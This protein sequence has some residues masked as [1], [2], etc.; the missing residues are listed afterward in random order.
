MLN[1]FVVRDMVEDAYAGIILGRPFLSTS[2]YKIDVKGGHLRFDMGE[3]HTEFSLF[4]DRNFLPSLFAC[5]EVIISNAIVKFDNLCPNDPPMFDCVSTKGL[6]LDCANVG[7]DAH[8]ALIITKDEPYVFNEE[9]MNDCY[10]FSRVLMS[11]PLMDG[12][13]YDFNLGAEFDSGQSDRVHYKIILFADYAIWTN[14]MLKKY[15][16]PI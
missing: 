10:R 2:G 14:L 16:H 9:S 5:G 11:L 8:V 13:Q 3:C 4:K 1:D 7:L 6:E 12:V 15:L